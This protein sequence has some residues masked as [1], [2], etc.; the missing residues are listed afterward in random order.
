MA[1]SIRE[2]L[3]DVIMDTLSTNN[4]NPDLSYEMACDIA[5]Q[6][7]A[8]FGITPLQQ[9]FEGSQLTVISKI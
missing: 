3:E 6:I 1:E 2:R 8:E 9:D 7:F 4:F 5:D